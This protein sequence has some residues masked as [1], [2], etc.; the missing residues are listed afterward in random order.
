CHQKV[1]VKSYYEACVMDSCKCDLG[2]DCECLCT[3]ISTYAQMCNNFGVP[4]N[5]RSQ[6]L[7]PI[8]CPR[9]TEYMPCISPCPLTTCETIRRNVTFNCDEEVFCTEGCR[10]NA[11]PQGMIY[12]DASYEKY[13]YNNDCEQ[14]PCK[15]GSINLK[16]ISKGRCLFCTCTSGERNCVP[17]PLPCDNGK[18]PIHSLSFSM[19]FSNVI[20]QIIGVQYRLCL[21]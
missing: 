10:P 5:W 2:G 17:I 19:L 6:E 14:K 16:E 15:E 1:H 7:C 4:V 8:Q 11:L 13:V 3:A 20:K 9:N 21:Q 18:V 12:T